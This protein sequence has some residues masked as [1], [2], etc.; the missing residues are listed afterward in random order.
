MVTAEQASGL[1]A[2]G[3]A[4][5]ELSRAGQFPQAVDAYRRLLEELEPEESALGGYLQ[6]KATLGLLLCYVRSG[7]LRAALD[8]WR[9]R[10]SLTRPGV[11]YLEAGQVSPLDQFLYR[12]VSAYL[13]AW[14]CPDRAEACREVAQRLAQAQHYAAE[15]DP[16][17]GELVRSHEAAL[18]DHIW[19]GEVPEQWECDQPTGEPLAFVHPEAWCEGGLQ[20]SRR[21]DYDAPPP[22][23]PLLVEEGPTRRHSWLWPW[24]YL[25][26]VPGVLCLSA[27]RGGVAADEPW[28]G[29]ILGGLVIGAILSLPGLAL[30]AMLRR[31]RFAGLVVGTLFTAWLFYPWNGVDDPSLVVLS[32]WFFW[33]VGAGLE[34]LGM[35]LADLFRSRGRKLLSEAEAA[36]TREEWP[37]ALS[38]LDLA[39]QKDPKNWRL[40]ANRALCQAALERPER[41]QASLEEASGG[42]ADLLT[43][44]R[45][46]GLWKRAEAGERGALEEALSCLRGNSLPVWR[47]RVACKLLAGGEEAAEQELSLGLQSFPRTGWLYVDRARLRLAAGR[48]HD[49]LP[50]LVRAI[51][52]DAAGPAARQARLLLAQLS[53]TSGEEEE[54]TPDPEVFVAGDTSF[55]VWFPERPEFTSGADGYHR[56]YLQRGEVHYLLEYK[57]DPEDRELRLCDLVPMSGKYSGP[58]FGSNNPEVMVD[59]TP[60][61]EGYMLLG[62]RKYTRMRGSEGDEILVRRMM[63]DEGTAGH[64]AERLYQLTMW[65]PRG[66]LE[67][68]FQFLASLAVTDLGRRPYHLFVPAFPLEQRTVTSQQG[69][70]LMFGVRGSD[71]RLP[72]WGPLANLTLAVKPRVLEVDDLEI[73]SE[74]REVTYAPFHRFV[75]YQHWGQPDAQGTRAYQAVTKGVA[76]Q[77][78][79]ALK[80]GPTRSV[81]ILASGFAAGSVR[82][83]AD[84]LA[85][86]DFETLG[87]FWMFG[88]DDIT[89]DPTLADEI[90]YAC[91]KLQVGKLSVVTQEFDEPCRQR[92][93]EG[94]RRCSSLRECRIFQ[95]LEKAPF[96]AFS[97]PEMDAL[98]RRAR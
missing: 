10:D 35:R 66:Q 96:P 55:S 36:L 87:F 65:G 31:R 18:L 39:L 3:H 47:V 82:A 72:T 25:F 58:M 91:N 74:S 83:L 56:L 4:A 26:G 22:S 21:L 37:A 50:D 40:H 16:R 52:L 63:V 95:R 59:P 38:R 29:Y 24:M 70:T 76:G 44:V 78:A 48:P 90:A 42:D 98:L 14:S 15:H 7:S 51:E 33:C 54:R 57:D 68:A 94:L 67:C 71:S 84:G 49:A 79:E 6:A 5:D 27:L 89:D 92:L 2:E 97:W 61:T 11:G 8:A 12:L 20:E 73:L 32:L 30:D 17:L 9:G 46:W 88:G 45:G 41:V 19:E 85:G 69:N 60:V 28:L 80:N 75:I 53:A 34:W 77:I 43:A 64:A 86:Q 62:M 23:I 81:L 93:L 1:C 13:V